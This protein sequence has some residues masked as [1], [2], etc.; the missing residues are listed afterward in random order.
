[1]KEIISKRFKKPYISLLLLSAVTVISGFAV[2]RA[3]LAGFA[4]TFIG[5]LSV[6]IIAVSVLMAAV[7]IYFLISPQGVIERIDDSIIFRIGFRKAV[8]SKNDILSIAPACFP[9]NPDKIQKNVIAVKYLADGAEKT[10]VCGDIP[11][12]QAVISK[13]RSIIE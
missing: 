13:L 5:Y 11:D 2:R 8:I 7:G 4:L 1:M 6:L 9:G 12:P 3:P 10:L